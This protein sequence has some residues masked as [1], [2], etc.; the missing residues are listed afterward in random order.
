MN[1]V[2]DHPWLVCAL[3]FLALSLA[4]RI[5]VALFRIRGSLDRETRSD[6]GTILV[7]TLTLNALIIGFTFSLAINRYELRKSYEQA[8]A[9]AIGT[10][11]LRADF[12]PAPDAIEVRALLTSYLGRR[13]A[14][15]SV[16]D[17]RQLEEIDARTTQLQ[18][19]L[20]ATVRTA[21]MLQPTPIAALTVVGMND[22]LNSRSATQAVGLDRIPRAAWILM[23]AIATLGNL[24]VGYGAQNARSEALL[25]MVLPCVLSISFLLIADIESP[26]GGLIRVDPLNLTS[27]AVSLHGQ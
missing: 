23:L 4:T 12:L 6:F 25:L 9:N 15:Y 13:I 3:S 19:D 24:L 5:G 11:Y 14:F 10:E 20:W 22:V 26:R 16:R 8:E 1:A 27:L 21:A 17:Q 7:A 2:L 18:S